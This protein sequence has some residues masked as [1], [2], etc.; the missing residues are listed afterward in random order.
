MPVLLDFR[1]LLFVQAS[2]C[3]A[4]ARSDHRSS[5]AYGWDRSLGS[6]ESCWFLL[7]DLI[8]TI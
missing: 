7:H 3:V 1:E 5:G 8:I 2:S 6:N 4:Q